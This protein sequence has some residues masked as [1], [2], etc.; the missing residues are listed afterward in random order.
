MHITANW[1]FGARESSLSCDL[2]LTCFLKSMVMLAE[3]QICLGG[4][5]LLLLLLL[6]LWS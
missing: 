2:K 4:I 6:L 5:L 3:S 1:P